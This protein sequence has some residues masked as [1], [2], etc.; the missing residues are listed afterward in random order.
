MAHQAHNICWNILA[1]NLIHRSPTYPEAELVSNLYFRFKPT[2][3]KEIGYFAESFARNIAE[4]T[5]CERQKYPANFDP[6]Q[7]DE[8]VLN[9]KTAERIRP[10]AYKWCKSYSG[11]S[12]AKKVLE[13][14]P[15][16]CP[17]RSDDFFACGCPLPFTERKGSAFSRP[18]IYTHCYEFFHENTAAFYNLQVVNALLV[19]GEMETVLRICNSKN[20]L[21]KWMMVRDCNCMVPDRGWDHVFRAALH[22]Y[23]ALNILT[24]FP[25]LWDPISRQAG[26][27]K[28]SEEY[29]GTLMYQKTL[30]TWTQEESNN[31]VPCYPHRQFFGLESHFY[32]SGKIKRYQKQPAFLALLAE[33]KT[34]ADIARVEEYLRIK[35]LP[36]ELVLQITAL[37]GYD[38]RRARR[39]PVP[40]DPLHKD[41]RRELRQYLTFCWKIMVRCNMMAQ[42]LGTEINWV[43]EVIHALG[44]MVTVPPGKKL[45]TTEWYEPDDIWPNGFNRSTMRGG[46]QEFPY[47]FRDSS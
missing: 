32:R 39:L 10:I 8:V 1:N 37:A 29:R 28:K 20:E 7:P 4:H 42:E 24:C 33:R 31:E 34:L 23:L 12:P 41:N 5:Q 26:N 40:H 36:Q 46:N 11:W 14:T 18:C 47:S 44:D 43:S 6:I 45:F 9:N 17:H 19:L 13:D 35:R 15:G 2:Q 25:E 38:S 27:K 3:G 30:R 22:F 21:A 16:V